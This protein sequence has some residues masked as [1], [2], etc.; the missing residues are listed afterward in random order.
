MSNYPERILVPVSCS[1]I[2]LLPNGSTLYDVACTDEQG[3]AVDE[4]F[5][6][7]VELELNVAQKFE[8]RPYNDPHRGTTFTLIPKERESRTAKLVVKVEDLEA[9]LTALENE[10]ES[11]VL[12]IV[13][14]RI[15][16]ALKDAAL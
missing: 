12:S 2:A 9:R 15:D 4:I 14:E 3:N 6:A 5:R 10:L 7:F 11:K 13:D 8:V 16:S 1:H